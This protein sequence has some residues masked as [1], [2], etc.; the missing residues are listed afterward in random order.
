VAAVG[1]DPLGVLS[2]LI[3]AHSGEDGGRA[4]TAVADR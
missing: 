2:A 3:A 4:V 1:E